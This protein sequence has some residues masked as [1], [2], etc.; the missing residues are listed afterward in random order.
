MSQVSP[1]PRSEPRAVVI[2]VGALDRPTIAT[3]DALARLQVGARRLGD[4]IRLRNA[5]RELQDLLAL[6]G[7]SG[8]LPVER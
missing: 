6:T 8:V 4:R 3:I 2:D 5:S 1:R 7:L